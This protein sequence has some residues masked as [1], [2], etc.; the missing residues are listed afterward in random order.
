[1]PGGNRTQLGNA[2]FDQLLYIPAAP[3]PIVA[4]GGSSVSTISVPG[5][6]IGDILSF[7]MIGPPAHLSLDNGYVSSNGVVTVSWYTDNT[8]VAAAGTVPLLLE[9]LR[10]ENTSLGLSAL[11]SSLT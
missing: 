9:V 4:A 2:V 6:L 1:M 11:P 8:G 3:Y 7:N 5:L 10:G